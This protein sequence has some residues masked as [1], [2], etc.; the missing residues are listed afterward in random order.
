[1]GRRIKTVSIDDMY[2]LQQLLL[3][4]LYGYVCAHAAGRFNGLDI[5]GEL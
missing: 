3:I 1:M 5:V 4:F 2:L